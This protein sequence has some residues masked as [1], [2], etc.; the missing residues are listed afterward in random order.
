[1]IGTSLLLAYYLAAGAAPASGTVTVAT[2]SGDGKMLRFVAGEADV[3][4]IPAWRPEEGQAAPLDLRPAINL[5]RDFVRK[6]HPETQEFDLS[7]VQL[8]HLEPPHQDQWYYLVQFRPVVGGQALKGGLYFACVL[9]NG[10][11][12]EPQEFTPK[13]QGE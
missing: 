4:S 3:A 9:M 10:T 11:V 7:S 6:R 1:M 13:R 8:A 5:G 2:L 12:I